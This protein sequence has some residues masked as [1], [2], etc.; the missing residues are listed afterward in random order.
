[1]KYGSWS[2]ESSLETQIPSKNR[3]GKYS[4]AGSS[5]YLSSTPDDG[6]EITLRKREKYPSTSSDSFSLDETL[7]GDQPEEQ[8]SGSVE[9][10]CEQKI[11]KLK[12]SN[13]SAPSILNKNSVSLAQ[14][15]NQS[16]SLKQP[17]LGLL[18][19]QN[20]APKQ[21]SLAVLA[22][23]NSSAKK[24]SLA[25]LAKEN[26][27]AKQLSLKQ[28]EEQN[29]VA[30]Q[31]PSTR[32]VNADLEPKQSSLVKLTK[33]NVTSY[34]PSLAQLATS[35][36]LLTTD[37]TG[38]QNPK[39]EQ[40]S[41]ADIANQTAIQ[42]KNNSGLGSLI[43]QIK[44]NEGKRK[45]SLFSDLSNSSGKQPSFSDLS[46][47]PE[48]QGPNI[49][50]SSNSSLSSIASQQTTRQP[51]LADL[52]KLHSST[53]TVQTSLV[54]LAKGK[55]SS[56]ADLASKQAT[57]PKK[58]SLAELAAMNSKSIPKQPKDF[59]SERY[60]EDRNLG[61]ESISLASLAT[62]KPVVQRLA[63]DDLAKKDGLV[64]GFSELK[65]TEKK[66]TLTD[67]VG[68]KSKLNNNKETGKISPTGH[69]GI[70]KEDSVEGHNLNL[71]DIT[72]HNDIAENMKG[73]L[74]RFKASILGQVLCLECGVC[75]SAIVKRKYPKFSYNCQAKYVKKTEVVIHKIIPFDFSTPSPDDIV[76]SRQKAAFTRT[77]ETK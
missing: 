7:L 34:Q 12:V 11:G 44:I 50:Q 60:T 66:I 61:K 15:A 53:T 5:E 75:K 70:M 54:D 43:C 21:C 52:A 22:N 76:K 62:K 58:T 29:I 38:N 18:A 25:E 4:S 49:R 72:F 10:K 69:S 8:S 1:M 36:N 41:L 71:P 47:P 9:Q 31:P 73:D 77:G 45:Q 28:I 33:E 14:L 56:L 30:K 26:T 68:N 2:S 19:N 59:T 37:K 42:A 40:M 16:S 46:N 24:T 17:K 32:I 27:G 3:M 48:K 6:K 13:N 20:K 67:L 74:L 65:V 57:D 63:G 39:P 55:M 64:H 35:H 23:Q 51:S